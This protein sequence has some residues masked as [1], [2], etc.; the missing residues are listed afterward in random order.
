[1]WAPYERTE[2]GFEKHLA[3]NHLGH[4][5]L[6][7][8]ILPRLTSTPGSRIV[9]LS[10]PAHRR[11][12]VDFDDLQPSQS[13]TG[14]RAMRAYAQSKLAN[15][16]FAYELH[17]RLA[18]A[19]APTAALAAHPGG[20]RSELNRT[21]PV[22]FR[23]ASWGIARP[24]THPAARGAL[25]ILRAATDPNAVGGQYYGPDGRFE[26]KGDPTVLQ[27]TPLSH[28]PEIQR[29]LWESSEELTGVRY[30]FS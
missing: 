16:L 11:A 29:R 21:M 25:S 1:M 5:A 23:G 22:L 14:Y 18:A 26:F 15:L 19:G 10:S 4:F 20:A 28:D 3:V 17:R 9:V 30:P 7:G 24:I 13:S 8:L 2:D 27:S 12:T 6:A